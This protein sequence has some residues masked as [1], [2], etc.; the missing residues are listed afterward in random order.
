MY[1]W[2][3]LMHYDKSRN[4]TYK[5]ESPFVVINHIPHLTFKEKNET[6]KA[7]EQ[8]LY[9]VFSKYIKE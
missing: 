5:K 1:G 7:I 4:N 3:D 6:K 8:Q 9:G 2:G